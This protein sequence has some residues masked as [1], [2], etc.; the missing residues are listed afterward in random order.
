MAWDIRRAIASAACIAAVVISPSAEAL[1]I[2]R[3][4]AARAQQ[5]DSIVEGTITQQTS[6]W[7]PSHA[8][9]LTD[10]TLQVTDDMKRPANESRPQTLVVR[11]PGGRIGNRFMRVSDTPELQS[12][13]SHAR[14][15][16]FLRR[17]R[18]HGVYHLV[19]GNAGLFHLQ[20][21]PVSH[22]EMVMGDT[23]Q[24][25]LPTPSPQSPSMSPVS[26]RV[27]TAAEGEATGTSTP[28]T[29]AEFRQHVRHLLTPKA[30]TQT[31]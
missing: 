16:M 2:R 6:H 11:I 12:L 30:G 27:N 25:S 26:H 31:P 18:T 20:R 22:E 19:S 14:V 21:D 8:L 9:I 28:M 7:H 13:Q 3:S 10:V 23:D 1:M 5:A 17:S 15:V 29:L 24:P 4:L